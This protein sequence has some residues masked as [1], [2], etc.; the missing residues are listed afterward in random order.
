MNLFWSTRSLTSNRE[1]HLTEFFAAALELSPV[2]RA[3]YAAL[4]LGEYASRQGWPE[5]TIAMVE[6]QV[7][8]RGTSCQ[9]DLRLTLHDGHVI[10]VEHKLEAPE[11]RDPNTGELNQLQRYLDLPVDG[12]AYVR[13]SF[14]S[15]PNVVLANP[16]YIRPSNRDHFLWRDFYPLLDD[17]DRFLGW[18]KEGFERLG[19]TPPLPW[20]GELAGPNSEE[21]RRNK[22]NFAKLWESTRQGARELGWHR[23][24]AG[25]IVE[26][27]L[28][29]GTSDLAA[30]VF[31]SPTKAER[32]LIRVTPKPG[33]LGAVVKV[34]EEAARSAL[35]PTEVAGVQVTR[36]EGKV[37]VVDVTTS[38]Y[39]LLS[40]EEKPA[41][42][43]RRLA[44]Y[45]LHFLSRL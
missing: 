18:L 37:N 6:T 2:F 33:R 30:S 25:D 34:M 7:P 39:A 43:E 22:E 20:I 32:F 23:I 11:T 10:L 36:K 28:S 8:Y 5:P 24:E 38:L 1:D 40:R 35:V 31:V 12:V 21:I 9:P 41:E 13:S 19:F 29:E 27:Y 26:L 16:K 14:R 17:Q 15:L 45:V 42:I 44:D 4:L 3:R